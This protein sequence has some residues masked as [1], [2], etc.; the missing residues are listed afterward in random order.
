MPA[1]GAKPPFEQFVQELVEV[2]AHLPVPILIALDAQSLQVRA[3]AAFRELTGHSDS[4]HMA[5]R[6]RGRP[7]ETRNLPTRLAAA[8]GSQVQDVPL[9]FDRDGE[10]VV[11]SASAWPLHDENGV[12]RG[13]IGLYTDIGVR[14][15]QER[16]AEIAR[17]ELHAA[18]ARYRLIAE[19][20]PQFVWVDDPEGKAVYANRRWLEY[21]GLSAEENAGYGWTA[22]VHPDD[23]K[24]LDPLRAQTLASGEDFEG[25]C[26]YRGSDGKYRWF[27]FR[28]I[29]VRDSRGAITS[30]IGT[31][32]D[33]D[34]QKRAEEQ[35]KFFATASERLG[36]TLD[37]RTA[38]E[39][40]AQL[41]VPA[42]ADWCMIDLL[43]PE[44]ELLRTVIIKHANPG[45]SARL[46][47]LLGRSHLAADS[48]FGPPLVARTGTA[49]IFPFIT[50]EMVGQAL[51]DAGD[52]ELV[53]DAGYCSAIVVPFAGKTVV[54]GTLTLVSADP[55]RLYTD[56]D[57]ATA[58]ELARRGAIAIRLS[59]IFE[60]E[61]LVATTLQRALLPAD[62]PHLPGV[63][64][65]S[66]YAAAVV[67]EQVGGDWYDAFPLPDG[68]V[69]LSIG[70]VAG[71]G[72]DAAVTMG[73]VRQ[74]LR[75]AALERTQPNDVL[76]RA[77]AALA[78][79]RR[80]TMVTAIFATYDPATRLLE[81]AVA[82]H[83][84]ARVVDLQGRVTVLQ[85]SGPPLGF[86]EET[87]PVE[88]MRATIAPG[89]S[90]I[91][92]TDGLVEY[93]HDIQEGENR[94]DDVLSHRLHAVAA[95][96]AAEIIARVLQGDQMDDIAV[97][98]MTL[99]AP[100]ETI[101]AVFPSIP[102]AAPAS[103][104]ALR[105]FAD[106]HHLNEEQTFALLCAAGEAVANAIEHPYESSEDGILHLRVQYEDGAVRLE[107][108]DYGRWQNT[109][110]VDRGRGFTIMKNIARS[111][112]VKKH[113]DGTTIRLRL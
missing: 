94:L 101:D 40:I 26:R 19:A 58:L 22:T 68:R 113:D 67:G 2:C 99:E 73:T 35:Q 10:E 34:R 71:H 76:E 46:Q 106:V 102:A 86:L 63:R 32:T 105:R 30:W 23:T 77:N 60:R 111:F 100:P 92:F 43:D 52:R 3:N 37:E 75:T 98:V 84:R 50:E 11:L 107:I 74:A 72:L 25:E 54:Y 88:M 104:A 9:E 97:L 47:D 39:R 13:S 103:R 56:S 110:S 45:K 16:A 18:E 66:A 70:D 20:M 12:V 28:S 78:L 85:G 4:A 7:L 51:H 59:R 21:I 65:H 5:M 69:A 109:V 112:E 82:G 38:L 44:T 49:Q 31:A 108:R 90:L 29:A 96:P 83:P 87:H 57:L 64:F 42:L 53:R 6:S 41:C 15:R 14:A 1:S 91:L 62:L 80:E 17:Q 8:S 55:A 24:R 61:H 93:T 36:S 89:A 79:D 27:L 95:N 81:Y 33:I 48:P